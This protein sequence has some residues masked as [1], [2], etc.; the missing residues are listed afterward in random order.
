MIDSVETNFRYTLAFLCFFEGKFQ[1][2]ESN[3]QISWD[4]NSNFC[5]AFC[6]KL[7]ISS[8]AWDGFSKYLWK[9]P[10]FLLFWIYFKWLDMFKNIRHKCKHCKNDEGKFGSINWDIITV[11]NI[12]IKFGYIDRGKKLYNYLGVC[13][14][15][16][17]GELGG[18]S[19][20]PFPTFSW[21]KIFFPT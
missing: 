3:I 4:I 8:H 20:G 17:K 21:S 15:V 13:R 7:N 5:C 14:T 6:V 2:S 16:G 9:A 10:S 19:G 18:T 1:F 12:T 11:K